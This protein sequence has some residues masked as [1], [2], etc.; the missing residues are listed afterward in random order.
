MAA[1]LYSLMIKLEITPSSVVLKENHDANDS[2]KKISR[3][4]L[5]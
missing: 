5:I 3:G 1:A 2:T 4:T